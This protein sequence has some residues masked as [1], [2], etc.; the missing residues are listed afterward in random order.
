MSN[1][2]ELTP[3]QIIAQMPCSSRAVS[4]A[5]P[6]INAMKKNGTTNKASKK[7]TTSKPDRVIGVNYF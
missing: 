4:A 5:L 6:T 1:Q 7:C 3:Q 2:S